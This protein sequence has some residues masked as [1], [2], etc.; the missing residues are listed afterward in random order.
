MNSPKSLL[1]GLLLAAACASQ[2]FAQAP[3]AEGPPKG[4]VKAGEGKAAMCIGC[5]GI[6][7]YKASFPEIYQV[8]MISGQNAEYIV[9]ALNAYKKGDRK[10][11]TMRGISA[12]LSEQDMA[13][14][15]AFYA[16]QGADRG[17]PVPDA[18]ARPLPANL[19]E[20]MVACVACHGANFNKPTAPA[21][22]KIAGQHGDYLLSALKSYRTDGN[23][24]IGRNNAIMR[25]QLV[26]EKDG[27]IVK[28]LYTNAEL[29]Q[30]ANYLASLP[31]DVKVVPQS[32]FRK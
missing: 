21:Y 24:N 19:Q 3:K 4:D 29:K 7:G 26:E 23:P 32:K 11:P 27:K 5:H 12:S 18:L 17:K 1:V 25:G 15:G 22:P 9:A 2:V 13:D 31:G 20:R 10:H 8:P 16:Q 14:L 6:V 28:Q 30:M